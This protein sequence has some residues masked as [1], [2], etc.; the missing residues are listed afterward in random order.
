MC[1]R[2]PDAYFP[3]LYCSFCSYDAS[4][5]AATSTEQNTLNKEKRIMVFRL[6]EGIIPFATFTAAVTQGYIYSVISLN[7]GLEWHD[8][9]VNYGRHDLTRKCAEQKKT[10]F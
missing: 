6:D 3:S 9:V 5:V 2:T 7:S 4:D 10:P 1:K 8:P